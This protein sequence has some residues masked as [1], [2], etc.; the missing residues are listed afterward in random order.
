MSKEIEAVFEKIRGF[1]D[2]I[3]EVVMKG[4]TDK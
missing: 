4:L 3:K 2:T 1:Q